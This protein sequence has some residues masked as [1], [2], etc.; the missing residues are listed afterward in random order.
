M[1]KI[2]F[3]QICWVL[4]FLLCSVISKAQLSGI[5]TIGGTSP[6]YSTINAAVTDLVAQGVTGAVVFNI[7]DG[8]YNEQVIIN[9]IPGASVLNTI[10]FQSENGDSSLVTIVNASITN[11]ANY[12]VNLDSA[13]FIT[14]RHVTLQATGLVYSNVLK[15][16][17]GSCHNQIFNCMFKGI[18][19]GGKLIY[20]D[21][22]IDSA[23]VIMNN[24]LLN[25]AIGI[26][27][28]LQPGSNDIET[29]NSVINNTFID[30]CVG[31]IGFG[32]QK[33]LL[34]KNNFIYSSVIHTNQNGNGWTGISFGKCYDNVEVSGNKVILKA[35]SCGGWIWGISMNGYLGSSNEGVKIINNTVDIT[36][37]Y[38]TATAIVYGIYLQ[39]GIFVH[40]YNNSVRT[41]GNN[42]NMFTFCSNP[43]YNSRIF[44]NI[45]ANFSVNDSSTAVKIAGD[46]G[47]NVMNYNCLY[48]T[49]KNLALMSNNNNYLESLSDW[50]QLTGADSNSISCNPMFTDS[51]LHVSSSSLV[52][53]RGLY[54]SEVTDDIEGSIRNN[55]PTI[56]AYELDNCYTGFK[57]VAN[58]A[59]SLSIYPNPA[60][61]TLNIESATK[62]SQLVISDVLGN[63]VIQQQVFNKA[64]SVDVS[65]LD[66]G[67]YFV[68][69]E[70]MEGNF[71]KI[72]VKE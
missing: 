22:H 51:L 32:N 67:I 23:N 1:N 47:T 59:L 50:Q 72:F 33:N 20:S 39:P 21:L 49:S 41:E 71:V 37:Y 53:G 25:G 24:L 10:T 66:R 64:V 17:N 43:S 62:F 70:G 36:N 26:E 69:V 7:R 16:S 65:G 4:F 27:F 34:I 11:T 63:V 58:S 12:T 15:F 40:L 28:A 30:Q 29:G 3:K 5:Y 44:N 13:S 35:D 8:I 9:T 19:K 61:N 14:L 2:Q 56:G 55:P 60:T 57:E 38:N 52:C 45:F 46:F 6:D 18:L 42:A 31:V 54:L 68:R 48:S